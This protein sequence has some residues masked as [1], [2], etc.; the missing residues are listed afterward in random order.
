MV[1]SI[2]IYGGLNSITLALIALGFSLTIGISGVANLAYGG[3]YLFAGLL[4]WMLFDG[5]GLPYFI[6]ILLSVV[7][8]GLLGA[9]M[10]WIVLLRVR[11]IVL[12]EVI[13]TLAIG[14]A[15]L[16]FFRWKGFIHYYGLPYFVKG[17][18]EIAGVTVD[19]HRLAIIGIGSVLI[20]VLWLFTHY[21]KIGLAFR[22]IAQEEYTGLSLGIKSDWIAMLG[23]AF[24]SALAAIAAITILPLG[25]ISIG[26]GYEVLLIAMAVAVVGGLGSTLGT[27]VA[28]LILGY[29]QVI[30]ATFLAPHW[31]MVVYLVAIIVVLAIKPSGLFGKFKELEERV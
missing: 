31:M 28:S 5:L 12:S 16:E 26:I 2:L 27:L 13:A 14:I 29:A 20:F 21:T 8:T 7:A 1:I 30:T 19:Y 9:L 18:L 17:S 23:V 25:T 4:T 22:A 6:A 3:F 24:G 15:I 11:G 10:Y